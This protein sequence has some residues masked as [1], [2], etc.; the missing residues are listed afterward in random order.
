MIV[1]FIKGFC[2]KYRIDNPYL[3]Q[4]MHGIWNFVSGRLD[5]LDRDF[6]EQLEP[7][8]DFEQILDLCCSTFGKKNI[9]LCTTP[10]DFNSVIGKIHWAK[11]HI[12][13][14]S[15]VCEHDK[16]LWAHERK[17]LIDDKDEN[18]LDFKTAGGLGF[19]LPRLWNSGH[20]NSER[21]IECLKDYLISLKKVETGTK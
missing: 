4:E 18:I 11:K 8:E 12:P 6:W 2:K 3:K 14:I 20:K 15:V 16:S 10:V 5:E 9:R 19:L 21:S 7:T 1:D 13:W 17:V